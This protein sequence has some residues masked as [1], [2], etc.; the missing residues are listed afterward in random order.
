[1]TTLLNIE[2]LS[3]AFHQYQT[4][5]QQGWTEKLSQVH[6]AI[7]QGEILAVVGASGSG[8]TLLAHCLM[9]ILAENAYWTGRISYKGEELDDKKIADLRGKEIAFIPQSV[10]ALDPLLT[11]GKHIQLT[12][13]LDPSSP[14]LQQAL[15]NY[16]LDPQVLDLYPHQLS[17]GMTRRILV[18]MA[19]LSQ[20]N[21]VIADEPNPGMDQAAIKE[22]IQLILDKKEQEIT[23]LLILH[24]LDLALELADRIA[25]FKDGQVVDLFDVEEF[26]SSTLAQRHPYTQDLFRARP[27][28]PTF[29]LQLKEGR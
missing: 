29:S 19:F 3:I 20:P 1:M 5:F 15:S 13:A 22:T 4:F 24:D 10:H 16:D 28:D 18:M 23:S 12:N 17:G 8:K 27:T 6:L 26:S 2:D 11:I 7:Q 14:L 21:C 25:V 9:G